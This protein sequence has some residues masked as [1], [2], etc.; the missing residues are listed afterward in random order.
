MW[1]FQ[2]IQNSYNAIKEGGNSVETL[3]CDY[4]T[5]RLFISL[6]HQKKDYREGK[7]LIHIGKKE[8]TLYTE[9]SLK[10]I[11]KPPHDVTFI[12]GLDEKK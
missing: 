4:A 7:S 3:G 1:T 2:G 11:T 10:R 5:I 12:A 8:N 9:S 6:Q